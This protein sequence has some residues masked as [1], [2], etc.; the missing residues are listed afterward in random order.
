MVNLNYG[1][2]QLLNNTAA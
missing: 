2:P 1:Q